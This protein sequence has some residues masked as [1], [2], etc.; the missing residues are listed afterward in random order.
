[1]EQIHWLRTICVWVLCPINGSLTFSI[2]FAVWFLCSLPETFSGCTETFIS[3]MAWN[4]VTKIHKWQTR[5]KC[6]VSAWVKQ[7]KY[8]TKKPQNEV[9]IRNQKGEIIWIVIMLFIVAVLCFSFRNIHVM[10]GTMIFATRIPAAGLEVPMTFWKSDSM[11]TY[12]LLL[13]AACDCNNDVSL[14]L[15]FCVAKYEMNIITIGCNLAQKI[16]LKMWNERDPQFSRQNERKKKKYW[17]TPSEYARLSLSNC[18][19]NSLFFC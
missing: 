2:N 10:M 9:I 15:T 8:S 1:M 7:Q 11:S 13:R 4:A 17:I 16:E 5:K 19:R 3:K 14:R 18:Q 12:N 6:A